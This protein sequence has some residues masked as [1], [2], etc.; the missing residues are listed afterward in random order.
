MI[1]SVTRS[2]ARPSP[3]RRDS[4]AAEC[5]P[6]FAPFLARSE[7]PLAGTGHDLSVFR[8]QTCQRQARHIQHLTVLAAHNNTAQAPV[9]EPEL[10]SLQRAF[11]LRADR[12][13]SNALAKSCWRP[14]FLGTNA[15]SI[16]SSE[17][18]SALPSREARSS[19]PTRRYTR[20]IHATGRGSDGNIETKTYRESRVAPAKERVLF[21]LSMAHQGGEF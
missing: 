17:V 9:A 5:S 19:T 14:R 4:T 8:S 15:S 3:Q 11:P 7:K 12:P 10:L 16:V 1:S 20:S 18:Q 6:T 2:R 21:E 13:K